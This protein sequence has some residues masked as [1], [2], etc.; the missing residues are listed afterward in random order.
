ML[1]KKIGEAVEAITV[2]ADALPRKLLQK[3]RTASTL[4]D[5]RC[6]KLV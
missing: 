1:Y 3:I 6:S 5:H 4:T 2:A